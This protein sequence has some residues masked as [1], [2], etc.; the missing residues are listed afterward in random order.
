MQWSKDEKNSC[1]IYNKL[2]LSFY[3][4]FGFSSP[5]LCYC[6]FI[7]PFVTSDFVTT[8]IKWVLGQKRQKL[9]LQSKI[10]WQPLS[11]LWWI[12][13][14]HTPFG[15]KRKRK[16]SDSV[17]WQKPLHPQKNKKKS[18]DTTPNAT[19]N[20]DYTTIADRLRTVSWDNDSNPI[21]VVKPT[22][23]I[24]TFPLTATVV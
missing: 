24:P 19:K 6:Y 7:L 3:A 4:Y 16:R 11:Y 22:N 10:C 18:N 2:T 8:Y 1:I 13:Q 5:F 15:Y 17:L 23:G 14:F 9:L 12:C 21:G 20:F